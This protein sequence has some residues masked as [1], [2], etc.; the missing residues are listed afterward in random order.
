M[1][2]L[3]LFDDTLYAI[4][5][6]KKLLC[7]DRRPFARIEPRAG[8]VLVQ[9]EPYIGQTTVELEIPF[10]LQRG[11]AYVCDPGAAFSRPVFFR[12]WN[13]IPSNSFLLVIESEGFYTICFAL[14]HLDQLISFSGADRGFYVTGLSGASRKA[15][16]VRPAL[17][18][19]QGDDLYS[20]LRKA[21]LQSLAETGGLGKGASDKVLPRWMD[22]IGWQIDGSQS[23][24][25]MIQKAYSLIE[26]G[27]PLEFALLEG[28]WQETALHS[29]ARRSEQM[30]VSF[31]ANSN[32]FPGGLKS[33]IH[34]LHRLGIKHVGVSHSMMGAKGG[35]HPK[36]AKNYDLPPD[37]EGR[38]FLGYDVGRTFQFYHD[39]YNHLREQGVAFV[40]VVDQNSPF[41]FCRSG[42][43]VTALY[44]HLQTALQAAGSVHFH[45]SH[46]NGGC[47][48]NPNLFYWGS[49][50][51]AEV[52]ADGSVIGN[53]QNSFWSQ[54]LVH[55]DDGPWKKATLPDVIFQALSGSHHLICNE[56]S[57][58][59]GHLKKMLLPSGA[60]LQP[61]QPLTLSAESLFVDPC[62]EK[63]ACMAWTSKGECGIAALFNFT[64]EYAPVMGRIGPRDI[65][66]LLEDRYAVQSH[67]HGFIG[68]YGMDER[69]SVRLQPDEADVLTFAPI[70]CGV[71]VLGFVDYYLSPG[72]ILE[73]DIEE[74]NVHISAMLGAP[75]RLYCEHEVFEVRRNGE[76][77]PWEHDSSQCLL[78]I[79]SHQTRLERHVNYTITFS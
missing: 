31:E 22:A 71:A 76:T 2:R 51:M 52:S 69:F 59:H 42:M 54:V 8:P 47:L 5:L 13:S 34:E 19:M 60:M 46:F 50:P 73:V 41:D 4:P 6:M 79:D 39:Y 57:G 53:L 29:K 21:L 15:N 45:G 25:A 43:D 27:Y 11:V 70:H 28:D 56:E 61:D 9:F 77:I 14:S 36:L 48:L 26:K 30:L 64:D 62:S 16:A 33:L 35:I 18:L 44:K 58:M 72:P 32:R 67:F 55:P 23:A 74:D 24:D 68:V 12:D 1:K 20:T 63:T 78:E 3:T 38:H 49:S 66:S 75:I 40:K 7:G 65:P 17:V 10:E 37:R